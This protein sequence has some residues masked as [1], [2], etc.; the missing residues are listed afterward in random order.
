MMV[1]SLTLV[2]VFDQVLMIGFG[3][4]ILNWVVFKF[5]FEATDISY[6]LSI[7]SISRVVSL[8]VLLPFFQTT[9]LKGWLKFRVLKSR[10]DMV[11]LIL[12]VMALVVD[13]GV[14]GLLYVARSK[15][16]VYASLSLWSSASWTVPVLIAAVLK[17]F[18][19]SKV[20]EFY[21]AQALLQN[22]LMVVGPLAIMGIY[23]WSLTNE[24]TVLSF[25]FMAVSWPC[26]SL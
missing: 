25:C 3:Q 4:V 23:K 7:F 8:L 11:D 2:I 26:S 12:I 14:F 19:T 10:L 18:P 13:I 21:S 20:G 6:L 1:I 5:D 16:D 9:V 15:A 24:W 22:I 17:Y